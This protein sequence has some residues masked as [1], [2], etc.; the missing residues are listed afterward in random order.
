MKTNRL[1]R[2]VSD[3]TGRKLGRLEVIKRVIP[4]SIPH[5]SA[6][7]VKCV[8]GKEWIVS[9][10]SLRSGGTT[11]CG[12]KRTERAIELGK[13]SALPVGVAA[14]N[15]LLCNYKRGAR[16][17]GLVWG[18]PDEL[19]DRLVR[20]NCHYCAKVPSNVFVRRCRS[21]GSFTYNGID[22][23][24]SSKGYTLGNSVSCCE[25]CNRM[26]GSMTVREFYQQ[27][28]IISTFFKVPLAEI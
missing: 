12:C 25:V 28:R 13:K 27:A 1:Q 21:N 15:A 14:R 11:S 26:K 5:A 7:L 16:N 20:G 2:K 22:R 9:G 3:L 24:D 8:C 4:S 23:K 10:S 17:R 19:F 18:I 6:W